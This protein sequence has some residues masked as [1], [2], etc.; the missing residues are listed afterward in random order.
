MLNKE[1]ELT[2]NLAFQEARDRHHEHVTVEHL[3]LALLDNTSAAVVLRACGA[4]LIRLKRKLNQFINENT[5]LIPSRDFSRE[6]QPT[7]GFQRVLQRALFHVQTSGKTEVTGA[8][9]LAAIFSEQ[10]CH[11]VY[12]LKEEN[13]TRLDVLNYISHGLSHLENRDSM[14]QKGFHQGGFLSC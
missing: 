6:L 4:D 11:G 1:L 13:V 2:L 9:V 10:D 3:L 12:F 7:L 5:P 8:N 14:E